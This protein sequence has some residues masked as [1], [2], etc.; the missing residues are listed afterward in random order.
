MILNRLKSLAKSLLPKTQKQLEEEY[1]AKSQDLTDL[2]RRVKKLEN[3]N[4]SGW[5]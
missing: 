4:L 5:L 2:E 3:P 1:L